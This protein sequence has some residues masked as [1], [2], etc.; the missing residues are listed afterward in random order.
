MNNNILFSAITEKKGVTNLPSAVGLIGSMRVDI[1]LLQSPELMD[2]SC[3]REI[4]TVILRLLRR[5]FQQK[6]WPYFFYLSIKTF[7]VGTHLKA[8]R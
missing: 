4:I 6:K 7:V 3:L 1:S 8:S 5:S 2:S